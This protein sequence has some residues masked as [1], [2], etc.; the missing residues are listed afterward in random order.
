MTCKRLPKQ[1]E[2]RLTL[3]KIQVFGHQEKCYVGRNS[4]NSHNFENTIS[5]VKHNGAA[6]CCED[7]F[8]QQE[9]VRSGG[10]VYR[11]DL[12]LKRRF[13]FQK[14]NDRKHTVKTTLK[15]FKGKHLNVL[16]WPSKNPDLKSI[17]NLWNDIKMAIH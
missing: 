15:W 7:G 8:Q 9:L 6:S 11:I 3:T 5:T 12:R 1:T 4:K 10:M 2:K 17:K 14:N 16:K 13:T